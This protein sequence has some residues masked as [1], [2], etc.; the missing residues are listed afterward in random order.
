MAKL[1][2]EFTYWLNGHQTTLHCIHQ[3]WALSVFLNFFNNKK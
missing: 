3:S 2:L 1:N